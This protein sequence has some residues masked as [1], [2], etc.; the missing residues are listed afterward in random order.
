VFKAVLMDAAGKPIAT[1]VRGA[2]LQQGILTDEPTIESQTRDIAR[3]LG[4]DIWD[5]SIAAHMAMTRRRIERAQFLLSD[6]GRSHGECQPGL[7]DRRTEHHWQRDDETREAAVA[8]A[9]ERVRR[10]ERSLVLHAADPEPVLIVS[11][12]LPVSHR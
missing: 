10:A 4:K 6:I 8:A 7:F 3:T 1:S 9:S 11:A 2:L 5:E 12:D